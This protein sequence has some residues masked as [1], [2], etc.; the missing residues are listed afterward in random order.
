MS[1]NLR[2]G[3][4]VKH[5]NIWIPSIIDADAF[6]ESKMLLMWKY[7]ALFLSELIITEP[8]ISKKAVLL[9]SSTQK[10]SPSKFQH[11]SSQTWKEQFSTSYRK[12]KNPG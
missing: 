11:N 5:S 12:T 6:P 7:N 3:C 9:P 8:K 10:Q 1:L 4:F 2:L